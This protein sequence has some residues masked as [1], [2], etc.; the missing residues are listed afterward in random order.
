MPKRTV[1]IVGALAVVVLIYLFNGAKSSNAN[2]STPEPAANQCKVSVTA[3][4][5]NVRKEA[6]SKADVVGKYKQ[7]A[8]LNADKKVTNGFRRVSDDHWIAAQFVKPVQ[9]SN[10]G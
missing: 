8:Q 1:I 10:C 6:D 7:G 3:D 4:V 2:G 9:G 5:L